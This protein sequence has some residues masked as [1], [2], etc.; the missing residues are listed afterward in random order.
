MRHYEIVFIVHPDQSEQVPAMIDRYKA[1][2]AFE[3][4]RCQ[5]GRVA[6]AGQFQRQHHV[7]QR[8]QCR[9][10]LERLK[11][12]AEQLRAQRGAAI[13]IQSEQV[14]AVQMHAAGAGRIQPGEQPQQ[15]RFSRSRS[16]DDGH[17]LARDDRQVDLMQN[18]ERARS[19]RHY[20][21]QAGGFNHECIDG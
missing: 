15:R 18:S 10:Q 1:A 20:F 3:H 16:T 9:Q 17:R 4:H 14:R 2:D 11:H 13:F 8:I 5:L 12:E 19:V 6:N 7:L 21:G